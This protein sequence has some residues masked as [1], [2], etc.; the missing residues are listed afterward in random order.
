MKDKLTKIS[1]PEDSNGYYF[2][3]SGNETDEQLENKLND[4]IEKYNHQSHE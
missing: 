1:N 4:I 2:S 3:V